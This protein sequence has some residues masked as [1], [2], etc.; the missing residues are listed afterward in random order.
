MN[1]LS[2]NTYE[3]KLN[4]LNIKI[5]EFLDVLDK[6]IKNDN[7]KN[8]K[9]KISLAL[10]YDVNII[11]DLCEKHIVN[12]KNDKLNKN[13]KILIHIEKNVLNNQI[14][15]YNTWNMIDEEN[16]IIIWKYLNLFLLL[17]S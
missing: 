5:I 7:I 17:V 16:K 1:N 10:I 4:I 8:Y 14:N 6:V 3:D 15:L 9:K 13:D 2:I 12:Y 11:Y